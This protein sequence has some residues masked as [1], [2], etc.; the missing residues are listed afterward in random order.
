MAQSNVRRTEQQWREIFARYESTSQTQRAFCQAEDIALAS[1]MRWR[2]R[3][4]LAVAKR[5]PAPNRSAA[6]AALPFVELAASPSGKAWSIELELP[7]GCVLR[8][9]P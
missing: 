1:F 9:R 7:G 6:P 5:R 3:L 4:G 2:D 8:V